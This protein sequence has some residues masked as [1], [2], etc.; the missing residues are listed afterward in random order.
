MLKKGLVLLFVLLIVIFTLVKGAEL[1]KINIVEGDA[2]KFV[3]EDL[4]SRYPNADI[5]IISTKELTN[6]F[7]NRYFEI[8]AKVTKSPHTP[9]PERV[10]IF[11]NYPVQNFVPQPQEIITSNCTVCYEPGCVLIF[12]E[13]AVI[14]SHTFPG[15]E[16]VSGYISNNPNTLH[17]VSETK[18]GW[19]VVWDSPNASYY[20]VVEILKDNKVTVTK[21]EKER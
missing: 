8:K 18:V 12:P 3:L 13:E 2:T 7:G 11:Y 1:F 10:H 19:R 14:A 6:E 17:S 16:L 5:E 9:C 15:T 4:R 21:I 20:Y